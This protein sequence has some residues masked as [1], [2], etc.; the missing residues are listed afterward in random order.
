MH[1]LDAAVKQTDLI[2]DV[3]LHKGEDTDFYLKKG[4]RVV[5]FEADPELAAAC[6][7][8]FATWIEEQKLVIVE[9]AIVSPEIL[10]KGSK[11]ITFYKNIENSVWG[12]VNEEWAARN[13]KLGAS[14]H[15]IEVPIV[16]F[17]ARLI[18]FGVPYY[19]KLDIEGADTACLKY[20]KESP[21]KPS[22]VSM[23]SEMVS[24]DKLRAEIALLDELG[25][26]GF[27]AVQQ[28]DIEKQS[29][30]KPASEG[31]EV[32]YR[33]QP[34]SSGMFGKELPGIWLDKDRILREYGN[35]F[36]LYR[37]F[38]NDSWMRRHAPTRFLIRVLQKLRGSPLPGW[39]DTHARHQSVLP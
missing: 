31:R 26:T 24:F 36:Q 20:L 6:R 32:A 15:T 27:K 21:V 4:F 10:A 5:A 1:A 25:Y 23:E 38:G 30:P 11:T 3:G 14:S 17:P 39:Y 12:T 34:G 29:I 16:D 7:K 22:Y 2:Y 13:E 35:I 19:L 37:M 9:G 28:Q 18:E 8:R 33:F